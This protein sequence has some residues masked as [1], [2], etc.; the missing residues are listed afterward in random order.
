MSIATHALH[1][2]TGAF[3]G[4]RAIPD[5]EHPD[6]MLLFR[7]D[8]HARRLANSARFFGCTQFD[9]GFFI[10]RMR[11][12]IQKN[13]PTTPI[14]IR[15]LI[16]TSDLDLS[17]RLHDIE[18]DVIIY[19]LELGDYLASD[20]ITCTISSWQRQQDASFP[21]RGKI[22]GAYITSALAKTEAYKRGFDEAILMNAAGKVSEGSAMNIFV[23]RNGIIRTPAITEDILEGVTRDSII[24]IARSL[25]YAVIEGQIDKSELYIADEVFFSGT[26]AKITPVKQIEHYILPVS[27]PITDIL[28]SRFDQITTGYDTEFSSWITRI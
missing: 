7:L 9:E 3:G 22:S 20:G 18:W 13:K 6:M 28:K 11:E 21:L 12:F 19:G 17:P 2:G 4:M 15:P 1:Y 14:Y 24:Q 26:A 5:P 25:G 23:V 16:Y 27:H 8:Q 10:E